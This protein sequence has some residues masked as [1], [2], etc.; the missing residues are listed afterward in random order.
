MY[1]HV[2][3]FEDMLDDY[4]GLHLGDFEWVGS[5]FA[6]AI[7]EV[8]VKCKWA[9]GW[10]AVFT[11][12]N[13][14][15]LFNVAEPN[16]KADRFAKENKKMFKRKLLLTFISKVGEAPENAKNKY[17]R[18]GLRIDE[19]LKAD[20]IRQEFYWNRTVFFL[21][22][23]KR[24]NHDNYRRK[25]YDNTV[26]LVVN[27]FK[28]TLIPD[29]RKIWNDKVEGQILFSDQEDKTLNFDREG[30]HEESSSNIGTMDHLKKELMAMG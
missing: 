19:I 7:N 10:K 14:E 22:R 18:C 21:D 2:E 5:K 28:S 15:Q 25:L 12:G 9:K 17:F 11:D 13:E 4:S 20:W 1:R 29:D 6:E 24:I 30:L 8:D 26:G 16:P 27:K 3:S 23:S